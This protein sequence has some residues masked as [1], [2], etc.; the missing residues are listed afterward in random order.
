MGQKKFEG[1]EKRLDLRFSSSGKNPLDYSLRDWTPLL[2]VAEC[3]IISSLISSTCHMYLLSESSLIVKSHHVILKTCGTTQPLKFLEEIYKEGF[4][5]SSLLYS[6]RNF[7]FPH[8]QPFPY[9]SRDDEIT[10]L[11]QLL[12][13][14]GSH[15]IL[16]TPDWMGIFWMVEKDPAECPSFCEISMTGLSPDITSKFYSVSKDDGYKIITRLLGTKDIDYYQFEPL[17]VS[18][19]GLSKETTIHI[20]PEDEF[21][22]L[23]VEKNEV[24][25]VEE[26]IKFFRPRDMIKISIV[27]NP[28]SPH[29]P[30]DGFYFYLC[31][32]LFLFI[33]KTSFHSLLKE[34]F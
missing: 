34:R 23:S 12:P 18:V 30:D 33:E 21:S 26:W 19:N 13:Q 15:K 1:P 20:T 6:H 17:G 24:F 27:K 29:N 28:P 32:D 16:T 22:Y 10:S 5:I 3:Q 25:G 8:D 4:I 7:L 14:G 11:V 2:R 9:S 31:Q